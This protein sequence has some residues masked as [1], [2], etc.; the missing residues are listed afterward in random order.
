MRK[1]PGPTK[2]GPCRDLD[3][4]RCHGGLGGA[5]VRPTRPFGGDWSGEDGVAV[6]RRSC[7]ARSSRSPRRRWRRQRGLRRRRGWGRGPRG[8]RC[9]DRAPPAEAGARRSVEEERRSVEEERASTPTW[10]AK[11]RICGF[12]WTYVLPRG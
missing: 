3:R 8:W 6:R 9:H 11:C 12:R 4:R 10:R 5:V 2:E 1:A 7:C